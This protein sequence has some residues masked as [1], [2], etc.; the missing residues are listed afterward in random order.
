M[1][2]VSDIRCAGIEDGCATVPVLQFIAIGY[3]DGV[4]EP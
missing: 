3:D 4:E 2:H 1:L